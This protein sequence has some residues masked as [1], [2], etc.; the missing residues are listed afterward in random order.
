MSLRDCFFSCY[1]SKNQVS[2]FYIISLLCLLILECSIKAKWF[3]FQLYNMNIGK[4]H[5]IF[6]IYWFFTPRSSA[7]QWVTQSF[8]NCFIGHSFVL[9]DIFY[10][11]SISSSCFQSTFLVLEPLWRYNWFDDFFINFT[12][13]E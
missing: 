12:A 10:F 4:R 5:M 9:I 2:L 8:N 11:K 6:S 1:F 13:L 3:I 7:M